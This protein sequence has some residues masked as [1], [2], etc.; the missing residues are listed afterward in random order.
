MAMPGLFQGKRVEIAGA[1]LLPPPAGGTSVHIRLP[2]E[3][4]LQASA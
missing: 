1:M 3:R 2:L 4:L